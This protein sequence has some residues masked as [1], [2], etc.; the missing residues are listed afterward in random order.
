MK[1]FKLFL[2][3]F[4]TGINFLKSQDLQ[5]IVPLSPNAAAITK[6]GEIPIGH[7]TGVPSIGI[8][9]YTVSSGNLSL[10]LSLSYHAGGNRVESI[11]SWVGLGWSLGTIPSISRSVRGIPDEK[12][13][14]FSKFSGKTVKELWELPS[15]DN[16]LNTFRTRLFE[17]SADSE[18]DIFNYSIVGES[19]KFFWNQETETF[20]TYPK[21]NTKII[22]DNS[23]FKL[24]D[25]NGIEYLF[26]ITE[27]TSSSGAT[28]SDPIKS[29]WY[30]SKIESANKKHSIRLTYQLEVQTTK[31]RS[32][33]TKHQ[34]IGGESHSNGL[35]SQ[36]NNSILTINQSYVMVPDSIVFSKG[37]VK[38][39]RNTIPREDLQGSKNLKNISIYN[40]QN[41]LIK[42]HEF[43]FRYKG[44]NTS[45]ACY[46]VDSYSRKWMFL[47]K[48]EQISNDS[49]VKL[50]HLFNYN[51]SIS[52]PCRWSAAQDYWGYY[53]GYD[54][55]NSL[56]PS[57]FIPNT[58]NQV[59]GANRQVHPNKS[60]FGVLEKIIYPTGGYTEF[61]Y[62]NNMVFEDDVSAQYSTDEEM[63]SGDEFIDFET[64]I[65]QINSFEKNFTINNPSDPILNNDNPNGGSQ[66][67]F[68]LL[69]PGCD[70][71][72]GANTCARFTIINLSTS[73]IYDIHTDGTSYYLPNGTYRMK[74][75]FN[76]S[77]PNYQDF[78]FTAKWNIL[79][80][81]QS[82]NKYVGGL[83]VKEIRS[84]TNS[85]SQPITKKYKYTTGYDS[86]TS[87]GG[88]FG[89]PNF[90]H[91]DVI[92]Y[93]YHGVNPLNPSAHYLAKTM[94]L[95]IR[96]ISNM[97][98]VTHS[99]SFVGY[100]NVIEET[101]DLDKTGYT[102]YKFSHLRDSYT[103]LGL[104][105]Q[106]Y[107]TV[108]GFNFTD[109]SDG[110]GFPYAPAE[111]ME[112]YRGQ[113]INL[114]KYKK[115]GN[116][117]NLVY[118]KSLGYT[119]S[120]FNLNSIYPKNSH[121]IKWAN[122][123]LSNEVLGFTNGFIYNRAQN[124]TKYNVLSGWNSLSSET[125]KQYDNNGQNPIITSKS[126]FYNNAHHLLKTRTET[127]NSKGEVLKRTIE[128]PQDLANP[129]LSE[130]DLINN[131]RLVVPIKIKTFKRV[132]TNPEKE[133]S[134]Q[135][136]TFN[137]T[138]WTGL[139]LPEKVQTS[140]G[141]N[142]L[143]D[144]VV[145]HSYDSIG[146]PTE[147]SKK[148]GT[149]IVYIWGYNETQ[150]IAKIDNATYSEVLS[151]VSNLQLLSNAD[152]DRT[153]DLINTNGTITKV[154][155]EGDLREALTALRTSLLNAQV[156]TYTYD[157]LI[158]VTSITDPRGQTVYY[159]YDNFNR[160][161]FVKDQEGNILSNT[162][163][164]YKN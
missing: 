145:Y 142:I 117:F 51:E 93:N 15:S 29:T 148:D 141:T 83:R 155:K 32:V 69:F 45:G 152:N 13:G 9:I 118:E 16:K 65:P 23:N 94:Y 66:M 34:Y 151:Q 114:S 121:G 95:R 157:P 137:N 123:L 37:Y 2:F 143:E 164:N 30:A 88:I 135:Y 86:N 62:E 104:R 81:S 70:L 97:Q 18:P 63:L 91:T 134:L 129:T 149:P 127:T 24:I 79:L 1:K 136:T 119:N 20:I 50:T 154:G 75:E 84:Y 10:P 38:F 43:T 44:G 57:F 89:S 22:R 49:S 90:S 112:L 68:T 131:N 71:S 41:Q 101:N 40:T 161:E 12:G 11:A 96:S 48:A 159:Q 106:A 146:N 5:N 35:P 139:N 132:G 60:S 33:T 36:V 144:R 14:Y 64:T 133:L 8:P 110:D 122:N 111:S 140:K 73:T 126:H 153:V 3:L 28:A 19:G 42:K 160:L 4:F 103:F 31:T 58:T 59:E 47:D 162:K 100:K 39:N 107:F 116:N 120:A 87:S 163:Y 108:P 115:S 125:E 109:Q 102:E 21:S 76:Q 113:L 77:P 147:V 98:Q 74:A 72:Q 128:Y 78:I 130:Q 61:E 27:T 55:N 85:A 26:N 158:G 138:K 80:P 82:R 56:T 156:T 25:Q 52:F 46:S 7:F 150:P 99:G 67:T 92:Q 54:F 6:Y 124:M 105:F 17:G 53:N